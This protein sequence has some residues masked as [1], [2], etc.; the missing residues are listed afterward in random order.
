MRQNICGRRYS[1]VLD[2]VHRLL[3]EE[4]LF[5]MLTTI[6]CQALKIFNRLLGG[7]SLQLSNM[8]VQH[9]SVVPA[10]IEVGLLDSIMLIKINISYQL[11]CP[12]DI[13]K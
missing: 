12:L 4:F 3:K 13:V 10:L 8:L 2:F 7:Q 11:Q 5:G 1:E 9:L 6:M